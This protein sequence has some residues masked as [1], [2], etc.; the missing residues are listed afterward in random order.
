MVESPVQ[1]SSL[2]SQQFIQSR[3]IAVVIP[4]LN[5]ERTIAKVIEDFQRRSLERCSTFTTTTLRIRRLVSLKW[6]AKSAEAKAL[7]SHPC[8][9]AWTRIYTFLSVE[10]TP[11]R[12]T[13]LLVG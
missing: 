3:E 8:L 4:R 11:T 5:K 7:R 6:S 12:Q 2:T 1:G 9:R 10:M 13:M